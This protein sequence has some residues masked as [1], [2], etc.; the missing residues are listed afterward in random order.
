MTKKEL[1]AHP[2]YKYAM[3]KIIKYTPGYTFRMDWTQIPTAKGNALKIILEDAIK[4]GYL[5]CISLEPGLDSIA[6]ATYKRTHQTELI[7]M[8]GTTDP[9]WGEKHWGKEN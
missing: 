9:N 2:E 1:R 8:P 6:A 4:E 5:V 7:P 3:D